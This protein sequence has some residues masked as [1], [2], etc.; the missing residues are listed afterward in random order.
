MK[1]IPT[2]LALPLMQAVSHG[3]VLFAD[4]FDRS[5]TRNIDAALTGITD[6]TGS[7]LAADGVYTH[8]WIDPANSPGPQDGNAANGGGARIHSSTLQLAVGA[9]TSNAFV[10]HN[11][12]NAAILSGGGFSVSFEL[13]NV[14]GSF[15]GINIQQGGGF[16]LGMS[17]AEAAGTGDAFDLATSKMTG[18]FHDG[19]TIGATVPVNVASD[20][21]IALRGNGSL[22]WG[23]SSGTVAGL[24]AGSKFGTVT[25]DF[26]LADFNAGST[27]NYE[28]FFNAASQGTGSFTWSGTAENYIG[29]DA[30]DSAG[31]N[32]DNF[33]V[34][35]IPEPS[36]V[37]LG[38]LGLT[39][40]LRR[41]R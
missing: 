6:N 24:L 34:T 9:G 32:L 2:L 17:A 10:N 23:G 7:S 8:A 1:L 11:F 15:A 12:T 14:A 40:L 37:A 38:L 41:R 25:V 13:A 29:L 21:W 4:S 20:F 31:I 28:V 5:D 19:S 22:V 16:G 39:A 27:V 26:T 3:A 18:A 36:A 30:R 33:S 35:A